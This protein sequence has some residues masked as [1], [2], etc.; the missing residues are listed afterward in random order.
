MQISSRSTYHSK[1]HCASLLSQ[2][3]P[4][5][6]KKKV[7]RTFMTPPR[8]L[9][10]PGGFV[11]AKMSWLIYQVQG[12]ARTFAFLASSQGMLMQWV[13]GPHFE[14]HC[15]RLFQQPCPSP[16]GPVFLHEGCSF[17]TQLYVLF[18]LLF[19]SN[20]NPAC[21]FFWAEI[22]P[23]TLHT[24]SFSV[25]LGNEYISS[26]I[27]NRIRNGAKNNSDS[28]SQEI[29]SPDGYQPWSSH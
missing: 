1:P 5:K 6:K 27:N 3:P 4:L 25:L 28:Q 14:N 24:L 9:E 13:W 26:A 21:K 11:K 16:A 8:A 29:A 19:L 7:H 15:S 2:F 17:S 10:S 22:I 12:G 18:F 20:L 23:S